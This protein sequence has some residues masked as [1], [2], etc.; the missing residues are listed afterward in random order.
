MSEAAAADHEQAPTVPAEETRS[1]AYLKQVH[2]QY[3]EFY[4]Q[5]ETQELLSNEPKHK[6][7]SILQ[8]E[9]R[10]QT[11][12]DIALSWVYRTLKLR[13]R[14]EARPEARTEAE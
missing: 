9:F 11:G 4:N 10:N 5:A 13:A 14:T 6:H 2:K 3:E 7:A 8:N 1:R 12:E